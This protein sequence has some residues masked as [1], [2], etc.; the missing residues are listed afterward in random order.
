MCRSKTLSRLNGTKYTEGQRRI[1][2]SLNGNTSTQQS[3]EECVLVGFFEL[4]PIVVTLFPSSNCSYPVAGRTVTSHRTCNRKRS[5]KS[6][7]M[8]E[9]FSLPNL[10]L[11]LRFS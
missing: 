8:K 7:D 1:G 6:L 5:F 11:G 9:T 2:D 3:L 4:F 10:T